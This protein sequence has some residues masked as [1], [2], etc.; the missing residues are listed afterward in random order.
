MKN[1][2]RSNLSKNNGQTLLEAALILTYR[3]ESITPLICE[4]YTKV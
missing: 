2:F 3:M 4:T 1:L